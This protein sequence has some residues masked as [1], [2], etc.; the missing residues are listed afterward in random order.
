[1]TIVHWVMCMLLIQWDSGLFSYG[2]SVTFIS[3]SNWA[4]FS[5]L[6][7]FEPGTSLVESRHARMPKNPA[8][9]LSYVTVLLCINRLSSWYSFKNISPLYWSFWVLNCMVNGKFSFLYLNNLNF[10]YFALSDFCKFT[11][12]VYELV[13]IK[14]FYQKMFSIC[15]YV[16]LDLS[17]CDV[18][19]KT[20]FVSN[21][22][23]ERGV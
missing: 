13:H 10:S 2:K 12:L 21:G 3:L 4:K 18:Y 11:Q 23:N 14:Q 22:Q 5:S 8:F 16:C 7:G 15:F 1:M 20:L 19:I 6:P 9:F 17:F